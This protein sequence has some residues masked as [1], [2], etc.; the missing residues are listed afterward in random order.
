MH[1]FYLYHSSSLIP[2]SSFLTPDSSLLNPHSS[3]LIPHSSLLSL[4]LSLKKRL[5]LRLR[6]NQPQP[7]SFT[8]TLPLRCALGFGSGS[9]RSLSR[10]AGLFLSYNGALPHTPVTFLS[11]YKKVTKK[12]QGCR[13]FW[14]SCFE[15][16]P[17]NTTLPLTRDQTVL[18]TAGHRSKLQ[19]SRFSP[20]FSEAIWNPVKRSS[21]LQNNVNSG[22]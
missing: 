19:N 6:G 10:K 21:C 4:S 5:R 15:V 17:R 16:C 12:N 18:L 11:W 2:H 7:L 8:P 22:V 13:E 3:F 9:S 1:V 20:K 14:G